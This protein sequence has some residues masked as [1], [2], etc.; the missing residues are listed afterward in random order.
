MLCS[1]LGLMVFPVGV[2]AFQIRVGRGLAPAGIYSYC[3][4][5]LILSAA[6]R[7]LFSHISHRASAFISCSTLE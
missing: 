2:D 3:L 1:L 7:N 6:S 5:A 4:S